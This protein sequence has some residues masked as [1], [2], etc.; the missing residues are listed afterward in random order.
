MK[1]VFQG[2]LKPL[3]NLHQTRLKQ[4]KNFHIMYTLLLAS[5]RYLNENCIATYI[6]TYLTNLRGIIKIKSG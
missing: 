3:T 6:A 5:Y 1:I 4:D 2:V